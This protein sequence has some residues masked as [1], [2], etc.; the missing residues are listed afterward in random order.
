M[1]CTFASV[2]A[3]ADEALL[4]TSPESADDV[5]ILS[6]RIEALAKSRAKTDRHNKKNMPINPIK[7][8]PFFADIS[9][10]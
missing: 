3:P 10:L 8:L 4:Q 5:V 2:P 6:K 9:S 1:S 7:I